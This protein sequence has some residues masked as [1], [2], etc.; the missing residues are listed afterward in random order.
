MNRSIVYYDETG[1]VIRHTIGMEPDTSSMWLE[2]KDPHIDPLRC[3][4]KNGELISMGEAPSP[5]HTFNVSIGKWELDVATGWAKVRQ[6][7]DNLLIA[8]DWTQL[9]DVPSETKTVWADYRQALRDITSQTDPFNIVWPTPP[10][11]F[12]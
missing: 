5:N 10:Y 11:S 12:K 6:K 7:R 9:P 8:C 1:C 4:V 2:S 3:Y